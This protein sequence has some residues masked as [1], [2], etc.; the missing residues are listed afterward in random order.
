MK[1]GAL[2][3]ECD[4]CRLEREAISKAALAEQQVRTQ[5]VNRLRAEAAEKDRTDRFD[6]Y[7]SDCFAEFE[8]ALDEGRDPYIYGSTVINVESSFGDN[9]V[10]SPP[11]FGT[12][13]HL[14]I[15]GWELVGTVPSTFGQALTNINAGGAFGET[16]GAGVGGLVVG[17][18]LILRLRITRQ[19]LTTSRKMIIE[20]LEPH[21]LG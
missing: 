12:L 20:A 5:E 7:I 3:T 6:S 8:A 21:F 16:W 14:G 18:Y 1:A 10:G 9:T 17:A 11:D 4:S 2:R 19:M 15:R 13:Q